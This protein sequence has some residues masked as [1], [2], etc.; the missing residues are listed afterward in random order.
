MCGRFVLVSDLAAIEEAFGVPP[1][2]VEISKSYNIAPGITVAAVIVEETRRLVR[3]TWGL[4]PSWAKDPSIGNRLINA[5][6]ETLAEKPSFRNALKGRRC[7]II[8]D[9][10]YEWQKQGKRK[11]PMYF[12]LTSEKPFAFAGLYELWTSPDGEALRTC[13]IITTAANDLVRPIHSRMPAILPHTHETLWLD[14]GI[15][16]THRLLPLLKPYEADNMTMYE[17]APL[18]NSPFY[19]SPACI[20]P[21]SPP[22]A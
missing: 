16:D 4:V 1:S 12:C 2:S 19:D 21:V 13:T 10:F 7:L 17:V 18:V 15:H 3:F 5:R 6:A 20:T 11:V 8:A 22:S 14:P 9:G